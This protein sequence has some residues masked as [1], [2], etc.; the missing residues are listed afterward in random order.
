MSNQIQLIEY[1]SYYIYSEGELLTIYV[2]KRQL[3]GKKVDTI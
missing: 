1:K 2:S 3:S